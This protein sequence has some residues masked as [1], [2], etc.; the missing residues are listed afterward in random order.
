MSW[1]ELL[2]FDHFAAAKAGC[3]HADPL[4]R[5]AH[6]CVYRAQIDVPAPL[7]HVVSMTDVISELRLLAAYSTHL[8][9]SSTPKK[10]RT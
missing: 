4:I 6:L 7:G 1:L 5:L 3:A 8:S 2:C 9:H 10:F